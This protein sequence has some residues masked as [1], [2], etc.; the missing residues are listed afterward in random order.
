MAAIIQ[1]RRH[2]S[3]PPQRPALRL[4]TT[5]GNRTIEAPVDL[6]LGIS[7]VH[8]AAAVAAVVVAILLSV[9]IGSGA[10]AALSPAPPAAS[11]AAPASSA[12]TSAT[13]THIEVQAGDTLWTIAR[14]LQPSGDV[15]PLVDQLVR[16]NG[17][18]A[19]QPGQQIVAP[20]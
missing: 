18:T 9:A 14:R 1:P 15:R 20:A 12:S 6:G 16:L 10:L 7:P 17:T 8:I 3:L 13:T 11:A 5:Q 2:P 19:L 4:V